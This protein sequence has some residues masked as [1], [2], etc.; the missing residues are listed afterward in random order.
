MP[1]YCYA[2]VVIRGQVNNVDT[3][4]RELQADY[5]YYDDGCGYNRYHGDGTRHFYRIFEAIVVN[6]T[7]LTQWEK[8]SEVQIECAWS[9]YSCM[10]DG[11][12]SYYGD[13][14]EMP[15]PRFYNNVN[16]MEYH[17]RDQPK[18]RNFAL[19]EQYKRE[20]AEHILH[21]T[22]IRAEA[23]RL[24]LQVA[25]KSTEPGVG[26]AENYY[27]IGSTMITD[28]ELSYR[29]YYLGDC[30]T[31]EQ[32]EE[33]YGEEIPLTAEEYIDRKKEADYYAENEDYYYFNGSE[34]IYVNQPMCNRVMCKVQPIPTRE[35]KSWLLE[36]YN[37]KQ[38]K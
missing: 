9:V 27:M 32:Y 8:I 25:I 3:L 14:A 34:P 11:R 35:H 6:E 36:N 15:D 12:H 21:S 37:K 1:N 29:E 20:A 23:A 7:F 28:E 2:T 24:N 22:Y 31:K 38:Q 5:H 16:C 26:F 4:I 18:Y 33:E 17:Y 30:D 10:F 13:Y 19:Y